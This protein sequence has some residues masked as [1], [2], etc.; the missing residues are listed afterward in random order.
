MKAALSLACSV[1][2]LLAAS[3]GAA[4]TAPH[5]LSLTD[6]L[7]IAFDRNPQLLK[8]GQGFVNA[9][10]QSIQ[11]HAILYPTVNVQAL[12]APA[13][14]Y[15]QVNEVFYSP[16][17]FPQLRLSRL[18]REQT[19]INYRQT[20]EDVVFQVR[21]AFAAALGAREADRL[22][23][24]YS[25]RVSGS[26]NSA[27]QLFQAGKIQRSEVLAV[28][29][30]ENLRTQQQATVQLGAQQS[31]SALSNLLGEPLPPDVHLTGTLENRTPPSLDQP[32][33][34]AEALRDRSDLRLLESLR[35]SQQQQI[36]VDLKNAFPTVG[37]SSNSALQPPA[38]AGNDF[39]LER[40][41]DEPEIQRVEG[42]S[43]LPLSLYLTWIV[44]DGGALRGVG[45]G[46]RAQLASQAD[47]IAALRRSIP[48]EVAAAVAAVKAELATLHALGGNSSNDIRQS[49]ELDFQAGRIRQLDLVNFE[50]DIFHQDE[51]RLESRIR[52]SFALAALDHA[53]G[54]GLSTKPTSN[55]SG[56]P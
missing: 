50:S 42:D 11:F 22:L 26:L 7:R 13:T 53:L 55:L 40:N 28:Q 49:A 34:A 47:A 35:L 27:Q 33:L 24:D 32:T 23:R 21:Q 14:I 16:A 31:I 48:G 45:M 29:V 51:L 44:Y 5:D 30:D 17:T 37:F 36:L 38:F 3:A 1:A 20:L 46:D 19:E 39:D 43:Q 9:R 6:C 10:G 56:N 52:L 25:T 41:Y 2:L 12:T 8:A 15:L 54:R 18:T 4:P